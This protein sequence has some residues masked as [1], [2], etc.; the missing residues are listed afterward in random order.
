MTKVFVDIEGANNAGFASYAVADFNS[1][2]LM[3]SGTPAVINMITIT[4][5]QDNAAFTNNGMLNFYLAEDTT[6]GIQP[7]APPDVPAV[8]FDA[9][10]PEGL[11][12]QLAPVHFLGLGMFTQSDNGTQ[13]TFSFVPDCTTAPYVLGILSNGGALRFVIT[14]PDPDVAATYSGFSN[15][16]PI[17]PGPALTLDVSF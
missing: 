5:T 12:G 15:A 4:L 9:T 2:D 17:Y 10:D 11:N 14:P 7:A 16:N 6:T 3:I 1:S 8:I 13:D